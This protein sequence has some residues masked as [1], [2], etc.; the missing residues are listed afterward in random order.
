MW[1]GIKSLT[2]YKNTTMLSSQDRDLPDT[3]NLFFTRFDKQQG[4]AQPAERAQPEEEPT[5]I[6][7]QH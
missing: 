2:D 3:L 4:R 6:L 7:Q 1:R 5:I